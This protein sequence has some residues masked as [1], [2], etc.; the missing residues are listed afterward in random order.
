MVESG[1]KLRVTH[2]HKKPTLSV[3]AQAV[4]LLTNIFKTTA[5][6]GKTFAIATEHPAEF[7][8]HRKKKEKTRNQS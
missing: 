7:E 5:F 3:G 6:K 1:E 8:K 4:N 2:T